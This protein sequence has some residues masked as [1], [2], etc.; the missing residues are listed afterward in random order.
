VLIKLQNL[1][2]KEKL[3][4]YT[5]YQIDSVHGEDN[6]RKYKIKHDDGETKEFKTDYVLGFFGLIMQLGPIC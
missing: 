1:K 5:K 3:I 4:L 6:I 2:D